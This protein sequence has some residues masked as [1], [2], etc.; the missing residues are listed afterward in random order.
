MSV[1]PITDPKAA[2][3]A[4]PVTDEAFF[5]ALR[6]S[7]Y[8]NLD[9]GGHTYL[10]FTGGNLNPRSLIEAHQNMLL[11]SVLGNPHSTNPTSQLATQLVEEARAKILSFFNAAADYYCV[12]TTNATAALKLV[13]ESYPFTASSTLLMLSDN[14]NSVNG[15]RE[16][17][18]RR[19]GRTLY[20]PL[21]VE[22]LQI[23]EEKL[24]KLLEDGRG[25]GPNLFAF[26]AQ[27]NVSGVQHPLEWIARA[28]ALG[29]D[30]LLDGAAFVP[31]SRLDLSVWKPE[32][33]SVSF[34]KMFGFPT[35]IGCLLLKKSAFTKLSKS[36][37][38]GGTVTLVSVAEQ[39]Q[40]LA[41]GHERFEDGTLNYNMIPSVKNGLEY[42]E[43]IGM[44]RI[45][46]RVKAMAGWLAQQL[47]EIRHDNG[48]PVVRLFGPETFENRGGS[49]VLTFFDRDGKLY[50]FQE[51]EGLANERKISIRSGCFCNPGIDEIN[52]CVSTEE[53]A[54]YF[55]SRDRHSLP[56]MV[57]FLGR[58]RGA[59]RVS[60]GIANVQKDLDTF[61]DFVASLKN[62][63]IAEAL[64]R[65]EIKAI[66]HC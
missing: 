38:A 42:L 12:F 31:T 40:H 30:V 46:A 20:A 25:E 8:A 29:Y 34:Y 58:M 35:G 3:A 18:K 2:G 62:K 41:D 39:K 49:L 19:A 14:H 54:R 56:D 10:D 36:W 6:R 22:D 7:E 1:Q 9:A 63:T 59:T 11:E 60:V 16:F 65:N 13:G 23:N 33:V 21:N 32:F 37:F 4:S 48:K 55:A 17:V 5:E 26:P 45:S 57:K 51:V 28:Q 47:R 53:I 61:V 24:A 64:R 43:T 44:E 15:I 52:S 66:S 50:P 27:S